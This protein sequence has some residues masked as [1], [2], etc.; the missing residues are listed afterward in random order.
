MFVPGKP[1]QPS[2]MFVGEA[3]VYPRVEHLK[4]VSLGWAPA[5]PTNIRLGWKS[6]PNKISSLLWKSVNYKRKQF[7]ST[8]PM[9]YYFISWFLWSKMSHCKK[10]QT[11]MCYIFAQ[12]RLLGALPLFCLP[13]NIK[14]DEK[15]QV[16]QNLGGGGGFGPVERRENLLIFSIGSL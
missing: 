10:S 1:F 15:Q 14:G 4:C 7:Y 5:L 16:I 12:T 13:S 8:G 6:L 3:W 2:L 11:S 9:C